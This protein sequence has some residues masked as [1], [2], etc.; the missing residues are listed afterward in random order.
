MLLQDT[1]RGSSY[2]GYT[3]ASV[4]RA[5]AI[6]RKEDPSRVA[7]IPI[8]LN[9]IVMQAPLD[10]FVTQTR[11]VLFYGTP[12]GE[13]VLRASVSFEL[14]ANIIIK[15]QKAFVSQV[16]KRHDTSVPSAKTRL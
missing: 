8:P 3:D 9:R 6:T 13:L 2:L 15:A 5:A 4:R 1:H 12:G 11:R 14:V 16:F 10:N 7:L